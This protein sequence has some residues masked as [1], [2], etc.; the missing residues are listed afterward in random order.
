MKN[1]KCIV[2]LI[3]LTFKGQIEAG[4]GRADL[5]RWLSKLQNGPSVGAGFHSLSPTRNWPIGVFL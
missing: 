1:M 3:F 2:C 4:F 5:G